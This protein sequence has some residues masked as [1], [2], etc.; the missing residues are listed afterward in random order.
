MWWTIILCFIDNNCQRFSALPCTTPHLAISVFRPVLF[1]SFGISKSVSL[2]MHTND[3]HR[4]ENNSF[5]IVCNLHSE[6]R[7]QQ[8]V[9]GSL[10][11]RKCIAIIY[12][13]RNPRAASD[14]IIWKCDLF[15]IEYLFILSI[16]IANNHNCVFN[17]SIRMELTRNDQTIEAGPC[18][19]LERVCHACISRQL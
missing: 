1:L 2:A 4:N 11:I 5:W 6:H 3:T 13:T 18:N 15:L 12:L 17:K 19:E 9:P 10:S 16:A 8:Y 14:Q 7:T